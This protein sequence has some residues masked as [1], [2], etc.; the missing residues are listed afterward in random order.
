MTTDDPQRRSAEAWADYYAERDDGMRLYRQRKRANESVVSTWGIVDM[1]AALRQESLL[2]QIGRRDDGIALLYRSKPHVLHGDSYSGKTWCALCI[3]KQVLDAGG[4]VLYLD[5]EDDAKGIG[6]RL[7]RMGVQRDLIA[8]PTKRFDYVRPERSLDNDD[9]REHFDALLNNRYEY[10]VID[11]V[12]ESMS[13]EGL[14]LMLGAD[15][16]SWQAM[17]PRAIAT[18]TGA[19]VLCID[20]DVKDT[21]K[22]N[23][24][25][26]GSERKVSGVD[27]CV[28]VMQGAEPFMDGK[29]GAAVLRVGKDRHGE[30][31]KHG[32]NYD[33]KSRTHVLAH[34][35][36]DSTEEG[37][38]SA[39]LTVP[40]TPPPEE[41]DDEKTERQRKLCCWFMERVSQYFEDMVPD[42]ETYSKEKVIKAM[43][44]ERKEAGKKQQRDYWRDAIGFLIDEGYLSGPTEVP[45]G[46][47]CPLG[48]VKPYRQQAD[49]NSDRYRDPESQRPRVVRL[50]KRGE[51]A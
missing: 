16:A 34:F 23:G 22:R 43:C 44:E 9:E 20:H 7:I 38:S 29:V 28:F 50:P 11:G 26:I 1:D 35:E 37:T 42:G 19:A 18:R 47:A 15:V 4:A 25:P 21:E 10:A 5:F 8:G 45:K 13:F 41:T 51:G 17:L 49:P 24:A 31:N 40:S 32:V 36:L 14:N 33:A 2:P 3:A 48:F 39:R 6:E 12:T 27:G 46:K 30:V